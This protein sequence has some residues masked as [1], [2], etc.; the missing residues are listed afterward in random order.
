L[1]GWRSRAPTG[2]WLSKGRAS[3]WVSG[4]RADC[5]PPSAGRLPSACPLPAAG[6]LPLPVPFLRRVAFRLRDADADPA[7][8]RVPDPGPS[9]PQSHAGR[10]AGRAPA[11]L[12]LPR[13]RI[14]RVFRPVPLFLPVSSFRSLARNTPLPRNACPPVRLHSLRG[15][16][17]FHADA[18]GGPLRGYR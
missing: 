8:E 5:R 15:T 2:G 14:F 7:A 16:Q 10:R 4:G 11:P 6:R 3:D 18:G 9:V 17:A 1:A 13:F 12:A